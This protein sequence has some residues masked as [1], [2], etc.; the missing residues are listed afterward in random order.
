MKNEDISNISRIISLHYTCVCTNLK[1][2]C[3]K[4]EISVLEANG[5]RVN[6]LGHVLKPN[7]VFLQD[8]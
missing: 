4:A 8:S 2:L 7:Q 1:P 5:N 3:I 6:P